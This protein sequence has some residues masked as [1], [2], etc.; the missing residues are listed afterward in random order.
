MKLRFFV[1]Q[2]E[3]GLKIRRFR[4]NAGL[5]QEKLAELVGVTPQ[6]VQ[7]YETAKTRISTDRIQLIADALQVNVT[8]FFHERHEALTLNEAEALFIQKLRKV[9]D[10][11]L[12]ESLTVIMDRLAK[13]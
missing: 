6:Q 1:K 2:G 10:P 8:D 7:K 4:Q 3:I 5:S 12:Q 9:R 11:Q 13:Q